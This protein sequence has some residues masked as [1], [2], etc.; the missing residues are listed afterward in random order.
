[1]ITAPTRSSVVVETT[2]A[3]VDQPIPNAAPKSTVPEMFRL[4]TD[5]AADAWSNMAVVVDSQINIWTMKLTRMLLLV[6]LAIPLFT[7]LIAL[8]VY[9]FVLLNQAFAI[10][11]EW[12]DYP[13]WFSPLVRGAIYFGIPFIG[14]LVTWFT[15]IGLGT[16]SATASNDTSKTEYREEH[17]A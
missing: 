11:L 1:M 10:Y 6:A 3:D 16:S 17:H 5:H 8:M 9:G 7:A 15:M 2:I 13:H 12:P 14:A 4:V